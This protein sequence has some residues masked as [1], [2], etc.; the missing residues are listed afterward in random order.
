[1][2]LYYVIWF[3]V[4]C[5]VLYFNI[6][7]YII[8][9]IYYIII[10]YIIIYYIRL[11]YIIFYY[12]ILYYIL[13]YYIILYYIIFYF[14]IF[15]III[16]IYYIILYDLLCPWI[17]GGVNPRTAI[18]LVP[19]WYTKLLQLDKELWTTELPL[20]VLD[21]TTELIGELGL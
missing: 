11:Y 10:Y 2:L 14:I 17:Q 18:G 16:Y 19:S 7:Y 20:I 9:I 21:L 5:I 13:F 6:I 4:C 3:C 12:I 8:Y 15:Y 1:M